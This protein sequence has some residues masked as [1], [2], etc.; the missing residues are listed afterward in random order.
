LDDFEERKILYFGK[1][2]KIENSKF[3]DFFSKDR[4]FTTEYSLEKKRFSENGENWIKK[5]R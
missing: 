4:E 1:Q 5:I 3:N 2:L